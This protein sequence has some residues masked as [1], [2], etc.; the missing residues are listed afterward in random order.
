MP[1]R[2]RHRNLAS[3]SLSKIVKNC[4][5]KIPDSARS[6]DA[7]KEMPPRPTGY[8]HLP[9]GMDRQAIHKAVTAIIAVVS[10]PT[11]ISPGR[12]PGR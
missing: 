6:T 2:K 9:R 11:A 3:R 4:D 7:D 12:S 10:E 5:G 1:I 8:R